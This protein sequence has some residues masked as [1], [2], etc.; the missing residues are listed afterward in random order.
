MTAPVEIRS[1]FQAHWD[2]S[3]GRLQPTSWQKIWNVVSTILF[4]IGLTRVAVHKIGEIINP[5][6]LLPASEK[7]TSYVSKW[8]E[9]FIRYWDTQKESPFTLEPYTISTPDHVDLNATLIRHKEAT[10]DTPTVIYFNPNGAISFEM[11]Y[12]DLVQECLLRNAVCNFAVFDYR[13][14]G[15]SSGKF[16]FLDDLVIDGASIVQ[17]VREKIKTPAEKIKFYGWSLGGAISAKVKALNPN[18]TPGDYVN[19]RSFSSID[20]M[21]DVLFSSSSI[22]KIASR[23]LGA[24]V[25][26]VPDFERIKG[27]T[28]I[29]YHPQD[30]VI[31]YRASLEKALREIPHQSLK[32][33]YQPPSYYEL[34]N[35]HVTTLES[36]KDIAS[37]K[38]AMEVIGNFLF[39]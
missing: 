10:A 19:E 26:V 21:I 36:Y 31:P 12:H 2:S 23:C 1:S 3:F 5:Q 28:L 35:H 16:R 13:N 9:N 7:S 4:P 20:R 27:R 34:P 39:E 18:L 25:D 29:V 15:D 38:S 8:R 17:W 30:P 32:L 22:L 37:G 24:H 6:I 33:T 11:P 14:T